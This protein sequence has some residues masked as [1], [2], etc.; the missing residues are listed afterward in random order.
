MVT[1]LLVHCGNVVETCIPLR[2]IEEILRKACEPVEGL[3][4]IAVHYGAS[5]T[6]SGTV[7]HILSP[8]TIM[9]VY[10]RNVT[11]SLRSTEILAGHCGAL[12]FI[13][14]QVVHAVAEC[15]TY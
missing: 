3:Q 11:E 5:S 4:T 10:Y 2:Y 9:A 1:L 8:L 7:H 6:P 14:V 15:I 12:H 13:T